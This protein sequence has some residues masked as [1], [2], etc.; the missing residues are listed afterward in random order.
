[1]ADSIPVAAPDPSPASTP[2]AETAPASIGFT[3][4]DATPPAQT[5][6]T[7]TPVVE[8]PAAK[9]VTD[10]PA[11]IKLAA[12]ASKEAR[13]ARN[14]L[15]TVQKQLDDLKAAS[16]S[17]NK[18]QIE[19]DEIK[20]NPGKLLSMGLTADQ[21]LK[22]VL[23]P[24]GSEKPADPAIKALADEVAALKAKNEKDTKDAEERATNAKK[25]EESAVTKR[26]HE[27]VA[28]HISSLA[29]DFPFVDADD[30]EAITNN[31]VDW[32]DKNNYRIR[33]DEDVKHF[34][35]QAAKQLNDSRAKRFGPRLQKKNDNGEQ[36]I[37]SNGGIG[38]TDGKKP[39][40]TPAIAAAPTSLTPQSSPLPTP[41]KHFEI[42]FTK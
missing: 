32:C 40:L 33:G 28:G 3:A 7:E 38:F 23:N 37:A 15:A 35:K 26:A 16:G 8:T 5:E 41:R 13:D 22:A 25:E 4:P 30:A 20:A 10:S 11:A 18:S 29:D 21:I 42:G 31:I 6:T 17:S 39:S 36:R 12:K 24:D 14:Q 2:V 1:M 9:P 34:V 27:K 19:L